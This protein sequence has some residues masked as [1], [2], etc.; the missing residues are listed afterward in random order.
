MT[1]TSVFKKS[2]KKAKEQCIKQEN[3]ARY[4][5]SYSYLGFVYL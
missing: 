2:G 4:E 3:K 1:T 5:F